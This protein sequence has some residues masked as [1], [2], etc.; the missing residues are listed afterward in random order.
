MDVAGRSLLPVRAHVVLK[1]AASSGK[2]LSISTEKQTLLASMINKQGY[3]YPSV[4]RF[5]S[6]SFFF[7]SL[8]ACCLL[9][10][11]PRSL[12]LLVAVL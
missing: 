2:T 5:F 7:L 12:S 4:A 9:L 6:S 3:I 10:P 1:A 11:S 8:P